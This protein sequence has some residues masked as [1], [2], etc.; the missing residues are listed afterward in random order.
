MCI[1]HFIAW[2]GKGSNGVDVGNGVY[3]NQLSVGDQTETKKGFDR[4]REGQSVKPIVYIETSVI[5]YLTARPSRDVVIT[6]H[7][8]LTSEWWSKRDEYNLYISELVIGEASL[9]DE[10][11]AQKRIDALHEIPF[12]LKASND[13]EQ[14]AR[15]F[16]KQKAIPKKAE[17]DAIHVAYATVFELDYLLT[18]NCKHIAN[19]H[20]RK[21]IMATAKLKGYEIPI[22][23]TPEELLG[24]L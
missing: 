4:V 5:S 24:G 9:G 22:I 1:E 21:A 16:V 13:V 19:A 11:A 7:Q 17:A 10:D 18:W 6:A 2:D 12:L 23:C 3:F 20:L 14:L 15:Q 8:Q